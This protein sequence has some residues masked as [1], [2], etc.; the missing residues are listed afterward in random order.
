MVTE[1]NNN[2]FEKEV[3]KGKG[4]VMVDFWASWCG[5]CKMLSPVME[6]LHP[7]YKNKIKFAKVNVDE[8]QALAHEYG[9]MSIPCLIFFKDGEEVE[10]MV[11][12]SGEEELR[13]KIDSFI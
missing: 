3:A 7:E 4:I 6:K 13:E 12:F 2:T 11:G 8:H 1:L 10:R 9:V 5:P